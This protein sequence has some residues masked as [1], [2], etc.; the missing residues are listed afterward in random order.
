MAYISHWI[1]GA[2][3]SG[4]SGRTSPVYDTATGL[5]IT[6]VDLASVGNVDTAVGSATAAS[7]EWRHTSLS[8]R[9]EI[10]VAFRQLLH[11]ATDDVAKVITA[12]HRRVVTSRWSDPVTS[13][14]DLGFPTTRKT[15]RKTTD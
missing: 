7:R 9:S 4:T 2:V 10:L 8:K 1:G 5:Q 14:I 12:E 13:T 15:T 11:D 6:D 3:V